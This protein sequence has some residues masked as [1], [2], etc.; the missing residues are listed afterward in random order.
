MIE[1]LKSIDWISIFAFI[2]AIAGLLQII[3]I[4]REW[5]R[6]SKLHKTQSIK[7]DSSIQK[8]STFLI[9]L[10]RRNRIVMLLFVVYFITQIFFESMRLTG[11][12]GLITLFAGVVFMTQLIITFF[13]WI[14]KIAQEI[15]KN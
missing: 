12:K 7:P 3:N 9:Q 6:E 8:E 13:V 11:P 4:I 15:E 10:R 5:L 1:L 2:A 14:A